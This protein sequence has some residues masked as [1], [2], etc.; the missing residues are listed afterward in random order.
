M[1]FAVGAVGGLSDGH[2]LERF[3]TLDGDAAELA[4]AA[5]V[6]RHGPMVLRVARAVLRDEHGANDAFQATFLLLARKARSLWVRDSLGPWLHAVAF[7]V[8]S[9]SR[10]A[11]V[12]RSR[13]ERAASRPE[14]VESREWDRDDL[15]RLIHEEIGRLPQPYRLAVVTCHLEGLTQHEAARC[16]GWPIGTLQSRLARGRRGLRDRLER[17]G[18]A[19]SLMLLAGKLAPVPPALVA[20]TAKAAATLTLGGSTSGVIAPTVLAMIE[21]TTRGMLMTKLK[22]GAVAL[23]MACGLVGSGMGLGLGQNAKATDGPAQPFKLDSKPIPIAQPETILAEGGDPDRPIPPPADGPGFPYL[24]EFFE[25]QSVVGLKHHQEVASLTRHGYPIKSFD[26]AHYGSDNASPGRPTADRYNVNGYP[27]ILIVDGAGDEIARIGGIS[28]P[29]KIA[30]FYNENRTK[31]A[32]KAPAVEPASSV[33]PNRV[34]PLRDDEPGLTIPSNPKPWETVVRIKMHLSNTEWGFGS[35]TII[36]SSAEESIILT[37]AHTF[38]VKGQQQPSPKNF[39][40]PI[41]VDLFD[42]KLTGRQPAMVNCSERDLPAE[43]IDFDLPEDVCLIRIRPGRPLLTSPVIPP[44]WPFAKGMKM[45]ALG[46]TFGNDATAWDTTILDFWVP[47]KHVRSGVTTSAIKCSHRPK[48]GRSGG[49]LF[50]TNGYLAGVCSFAD[51]SEQAGLY[52]P[53]G[54]IHR[55]LDR[56]GMTSLYWS[57]ANDVLR[58]GPVDPVKVPTIVRDRPDSNEVEINGPKRPETPT[59]LDPNHAPTSRPDTLEPVPPRAVSDQDR[60]LNDLERKLDR[61]LKMMEDLTRE[62]PS[63]PP[64]GSFP[65]QM[66]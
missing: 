58:T 46:C 1:L 7:R 32:K 35:G 43:M 13:H 63:A 31:P 29:A 12:R 56:N 41:S 19:P 50:T 54:A 51:P 33:E 64:R 62:K 45:I 17:R 49:G 3:A 42:G 18:L 11:E 4:F 47:M 59:L 55:L 27:E 26:C 28:T 61:V 60:R 57:K 5:L 40:V 25:T 20:S 10:S 2:L 36:H 14:A 39:R 8:A 48:E 16:L 52:A 53:P 65:L 38:R 44:N 22:F 15:A 66:R 24:L 9:Q 34:E 37:C 30:A 21:T 23:V 6:E